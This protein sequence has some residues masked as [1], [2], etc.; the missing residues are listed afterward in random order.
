LGSFRFELIVV[1]VIKGAILDSFGLCNQALGPNR[2]TVPFASFLQKQT[3]RK[4]ASL[5][6]LIGFLA[7][8]VW[9]LWP[10]NIKLCNE[11]PRDK[12]LI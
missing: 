2:K 4:A 10:K 9:T 7:F 12:I 1:D 3:G 5:K 6:T 8:V 11:S